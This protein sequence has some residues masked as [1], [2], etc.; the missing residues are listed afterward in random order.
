M[1]PLLVQVETAAENVEQAKTNL[2]EAVA[3]AAQYHPVTDVAYAAGVTRQTVYAWMREVDAHPAPTP[4]EWAQMRAAWY[5]SGGEI[6]L[7]DDLR[8]WRERG[9]RRQQRAANVQEWLNVYCDAEDVPRIDAATL[10]AYLETLET[11]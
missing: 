10:I 1:K 3:L 11:D 6:E 7:L 8:N 2:V 4:Q 5:N 9:T